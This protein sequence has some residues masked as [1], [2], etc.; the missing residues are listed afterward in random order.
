MRG[1]NK[2]ILGK[3]NS[4]T[5]VENLN[6]QHNIPNSS[7]NSSVDSETN[8]HEES[9]VM[10]PKLS[11]S[12]LA[13]FLNEANDCTII[14]EDNKN[15]RSVENTVDDEKKSE[16]PEMW[17]ERLYKNEFV[18]KHKYSP[19]KFALKVTEPPTE[20]NPSV[21]S[22]STTFQKKLSF[23]GVNPG[24]AT[25]NYFKETARIPRKKNS[26]L[27]NN[28]NNFALSRTD[29]S[30][31]EI[32]GSSKNLQ[33]DTTPKNLNFTNF[34][35]IESDEFVRRGK[36][37]EVVNQ[38]LQVLTPTMSKD[39]LKEPSNELDN[40]LL[41][42]SNSNSFMFKLE[43]LSKKEG[44]FT[45]QKAI[46]GNLSG[47]IKHQESVKKLEIPKQR[48]LLPLKVNSIEFQ[49]CNS[50]HQGSKRSKLRFKRSGNKSRKRMVFR[51][52]CNDVLRQALQRHW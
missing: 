38:H 42:D 11:K 23:K 32:N 12:D 33:E 51:N 21:T 14:E 8:S 15:E 43:Q 1:R 2:K 48:N 16:K 28:F 26:V 24:N 30:N 4:F 17:H 41:P 3:P 36:S 5:Q 20:T 13:S 46:Q 37:N 9:T 25:Y 35:V 45:P 18:F 50:S 7:K 49:G 19:S 52:S 31:S 34:D 40:Y 29:N 6:H 44:L 22:P 27:T 47:F 10:V 39:N